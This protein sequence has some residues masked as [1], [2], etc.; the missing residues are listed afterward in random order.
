MFI[1]IFACVLNFHIMILQQ[2]QKN[3]TFVKIFKK[4]ILVMDPNI[5]VE[6]HFNLNSPA[7]GVDAD[8]QAKSDEKQTNQ[9]PDL[10]EYGV[11]I[12]DLYQ[13]GRNFVKG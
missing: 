5:N 2:K 3:L 10:S 6:E 13:M 7:N 11:S 1:M 9:A 4:Y 12:D 8:Q